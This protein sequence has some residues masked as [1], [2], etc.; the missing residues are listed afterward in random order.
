MA[1][2][3]SQSRSR[4]PGQ[5]AFNASIASPTQTADT[6]TCRAEPGNSFTSDAGS[7]TTTDGLAVDNQRLHGTDGRQMLGDAVP[8]VALV[9]AGVQRAGAGAEIDARRFQPV[10]RHRLAQH[11]EEGVALG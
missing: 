9:G 1:G 3:E 10:G 7:V 11:A 6:S 5:R 8:A 4:I 2:V